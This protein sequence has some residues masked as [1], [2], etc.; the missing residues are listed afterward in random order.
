MGYVDPGDCGLREQRQRRLRDRRVGYATARRTGIWTG[1]PHGVEQYCRDVATTQGQLHLLIY[2]H[3]STHISLSF[4]GQ[5]PAR[6]GNASGSLAQT[7]ACCEHGR[8]PMRLW[9]PQSG[10]PPRELRP[11]LGV[12]T[13]THHIS[14]HHS[15][16]GEGGWISR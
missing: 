5:L 15:T 14:V 11:P 7:V 10:G 8:R 16:Q 1:P 3:F 13:V 9:A 12:T 4:R 6:C 2:F